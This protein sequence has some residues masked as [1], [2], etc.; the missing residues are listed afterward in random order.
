MEGIIDSAHLT[1]ASFSTWTQY[2]SLQ[3]NFTVAVPCMPKVTSEPNSVGDF[4]VRDTVYKAS[5]EGTAVWIQVLEY[6]RNRIDIMSD[7]RFYLAVFKEVFA[8]EP[9]L[10]VCSFDNSIAYLGNQ[11]ALAEIEK[12]SEGSVRVMYFLCFAKDNSIFELATE[13]DSQAE[14]AVALVFSSFIDSFHFN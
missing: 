2:T 10:R 5:K 1:A 9:D 4:S 14:P 7:P 13:G 11:A 8:Y 12:T 6:P 3:H